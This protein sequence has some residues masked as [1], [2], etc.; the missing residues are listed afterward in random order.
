MAEGIS[1]NINVTKPSGQRIKNLVFIKTGKPVQME[2]M[3][4][5]AMNSYRASGGGGHLAAAGAVEAIILKKSSKEMR[6][7]LTDYI[8]I[9]GKLAPQAD[10]NWKVVH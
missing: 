8:K 4:T 3:Y 5:V 10:G 9:M 1:Y 7:I 2:K 6:S